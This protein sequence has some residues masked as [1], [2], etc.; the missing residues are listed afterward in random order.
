MEHVITILAWDCTDIGACNYDPMAIFEDGSCVYPDGCTDPTACN[1]DPA[2][3]CD[4]GSCTFAPCGN[5]IGDANLDGFV[6]ILDLVAVSSNFGCNG[7]CAGMGDSN[8]DG[9]VNVLD[10]IA[11]SSHFGNVCD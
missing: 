2:S 6:N 7:N 3:L 8:F 9:A 11:V 5:C 10:L 1:Y 4:N